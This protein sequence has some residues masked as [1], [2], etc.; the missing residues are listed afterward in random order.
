MNAKLDGLDSRFAEEAITNE[1]D[2]IQ[3]LEALGLWFDEKV[4]SRKSHTRIEVLKKDAKYEKIVNLVEK[5]KL[6]LEKARE[7]LPLWVNGS[8]D[9]SV[10]NDPENKKLVEDYLEL[11][12]NYSLIY[13]AANTD[14]SI[15]KFLKEKFVQENNIIKIN[16]EKQTEITSL[17]AIPWQRTARI[18]MPLEEQKKNSSKDAKKI[19]GFSR[20]IDF[21]KEKTKHLSAVKRKDTNASNNNPDWNPL[22]EFLSKRKD[23]IHFLCQQNK[24]TSS[25]NTFKSVLNNRWAFVGRNA[26]KKALDNKIG[27]LADYIENIKEKYRDKESEGFEKEKALDLY[28]ILMSVENNLS[29]NV[30]YTDMKKMIENQKKSLVEKY[31]GVINFKD[32]DFEKRAKNVMEFKKNTPSSPANKNPHSQIKGL[33]LEEFLSKDEEGIRDL[34]EMHKD[35]TRHT[36]KWMFSQHKKIGGILGKNNAPDQQIKL[37]SSCIKI[38]KEKYPSEHSR[39][40]QVLALY[41][42]L[43]ELENNIKSGYMNK[44]GMQKMIQEQKRVLTEEYSPIITSQKESE[45]DFKQESKTSNTSYQIDVSDRVTIKD[46]GKNLILEAKKQMNQTSDKHTSKYNNKMK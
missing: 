12:Y 19:E 5:N 31:E 11:T 8:N 32:V 45:E 39:D 34:Y 20:F 35:N 33:S 9:L 10:Y 41:S 28:S 7:A 24:N 4:S 29:K 36:G 40:H 18:V 22:E 43:E 26:K 16:E 25:T 27:L 46:W 13:M 2:F 15:E 1:R 38:I 30:I 17:L 3:A 21:I 42:V 14:G 44:S 23:D 37:L 6:I